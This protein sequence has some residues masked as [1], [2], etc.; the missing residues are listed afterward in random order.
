MHLF[1]TKVFRMLSKQE[2]LLG[3]K[4]RS[5]GMHQ[6]GW[7]KK[8]NLITEIQHHIHVGN[9]PQQRKCD[10][11]TKRVTFVR[12]QILP[13]LTTLFKWQLLD[14]LLGLV[15]GCVNKE[16]HILLHLKLFY[17]Y[18]SPRR[19]LPNFGGGSQIACSTFFLPHGQLDCTK[20]RTQTKRSHQ[21]RNR[22]PVRKLMATTNPKQTVHC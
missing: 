9:H 15:I 5:Q 12:S 16:G 10:F 1:R 4:E 19:M 6:I 14:P 18:A 21:F 17:Y 8:S 22:Q 2:L 11:V 20:I 3:P 13:T 7:G